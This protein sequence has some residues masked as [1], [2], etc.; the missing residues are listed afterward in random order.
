[1]LLTSFPF[2]HSSMACILFCSPYCVPLFG[3]PRASYFTLL[4]TQLLKSPSYAVG[5]TGHRQLQL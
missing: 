3:S 4:Q 5:A 2:I 1:V